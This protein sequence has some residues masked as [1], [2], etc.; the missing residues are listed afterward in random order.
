MSWAP[1]TPELEKKYK[2][3]KAYLVNGGSRK[4]AP[5]WVEETISEINDYYKDI[6]AEPDGK[7]YM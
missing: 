7:A 6:M 2:Q 3:V 4:N 5:A 1:L